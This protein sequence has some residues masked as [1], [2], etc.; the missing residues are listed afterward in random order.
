MRAEVD[1][2][3]APSVYKPMRLANIETLSCAYHG[4]G[5]CEAMTQSHL[6]SLFLS[7]SDFTDQS[8]IIVVHGQVV[9]SLKTVGEH[10]FL[11]LQNVVDESGRLVL[12]MGGVYKLSK[13]L[14]SEFEEAGRLHDDYSGLEADRFVSVPWLGV[15]PNSFLM[16]HQT[17]NDV[18][19]HAW[20]Q[21]AGEA[22]TRH[23]LIEIAATV[24]DE[25]GHFGS[26]EVLEKH[27]QLMTDEFLRKLEAKRTQLQQTY[28]QL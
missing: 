13:R 26:A 11:A 17:F 10:S 8:L 2:Q 27:R 7:S 6:G 16:N 14:Y 1:K 3:S 12:A 28:E 23:E 19:V 5:S 25:H 20:L 4:A 18:T 15:A 9:G 24:I 22:L 21:V